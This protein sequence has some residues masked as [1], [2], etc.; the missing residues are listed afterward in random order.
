MSRSLFTILTAGLLIG[1][2]TG[3]ALAA[4][5]PDFTPAPPIEH[6][7]EARLQPPPSTPYAMNYTDEVAQSL[8]VV[9]G[10]ADFIDTGHSDNDLLPA[11]K[12]GVDRGGAML[13]LQWHPGE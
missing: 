1:A 2:G 10:R 3:A 6:Q 12:A 8:G 7:M 5:L 13:R 9:G 11:L 4:H